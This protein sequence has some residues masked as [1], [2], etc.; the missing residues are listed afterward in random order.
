MQNDSRIDF[1]YLVIYTHGL[2]YEYV[3]S[4]DSSSYQEALHI[5]RN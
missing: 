2:V 5:Y 4:Y 3:C 1:S